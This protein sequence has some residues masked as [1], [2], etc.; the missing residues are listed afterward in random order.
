MFPVVGSGEGRWSFIHADDAAA[1]T[2]AALERGTAGVYN[3]VDDEPARA[4]DWIPVYASTLGA[5]RPLRLPAWLGRLAAGATAVQ[6]MTEQ[7]GASNTKA[8]VELEWQPRY[9]S[10]RDGFRTAGG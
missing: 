3:I 2:V 1:A 6:G 4:A 7:R 10:W 9:A 8:K 5:K